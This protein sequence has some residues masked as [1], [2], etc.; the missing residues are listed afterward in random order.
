MT[1]FVKSFPWGSL[2]RLTA[3][4]T[5]LDGAAIDPA[6]VAVRTRKPDLSF[7]TQ[8]YGTDAAVIRDGA[9]LY[10]CDI[11]ASLHGAWTYRWESTGDGQAATEGAFKVPESVFEGDA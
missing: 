8:T 7:T 4:F 1:A 6:T 10:H 5:G 2:V 3:A 11:D 9:G